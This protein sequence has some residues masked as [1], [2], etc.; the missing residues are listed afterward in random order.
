MC[1]IRP[2]G[3]QR[4][5]DVEGVG[6]E[7]SAKPSKTYPCRESKGKAQ[8]QELS[9][10]RSPL[11]Q[12]VAKILRLRVRVCVLVLPPLIYKWLSQSDAVR[13]PPVEKGGRGRGGQ[14]SSKRRGE[15]HGLQACRKCGMMIASPWQAQLILQG[16]A[17]PLRSDTAFLIHA[18]TVPYSSGIS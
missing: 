8:G 9:F 13:L 5:E 14:Q 6:S 2:L 1:L 3:R 17:F 18:C 7:S 16:N 4:W 10:K 15:K 11:V 12:E